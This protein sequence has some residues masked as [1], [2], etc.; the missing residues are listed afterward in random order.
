MTLIAEH[1]KDAATEQE[2]TEHGF[3]R[4]AAG[5]FARARGTDGEDIFIPATLR[6]LAFVSAHAMSAHRPLDVT[7]QVLTGLFWPEMKTYVEARIKSCLSC[8]A[9]LPPVVQRAYGCTLYGD[10]VGATLYMDVCQVTKDSRGREYYLLIRDDLSKYTSVHVLEACDSQHV[11][12]AFMDFLQAHSVIPD[13]I[14]TDAGSHFAALFESC[15]KTLGIAHVVNHPGNHKATGAAERTIRTVNDSL[16]SVLAANGCFPAQWTTYLPLVVL[17]LNNTRYQQL[18][19][20]APIE[21]WSGRPPLTIADLLTRSARITPTQPLTEEQ[22]TAI[23]RATRE[24]LAR[25]ETD[26]LNR[27]AEQRAKEHSRRAHGH[28]VDNTPLRVGDYVL[29]SE[30]AFPGERG[31]REYKLSPK[32]LGPFVIVCAVNANKWTVRRLGSEDNYDVL[33]E[34]LRV[35]HPLDDTDATLERLVRQADRSVLDRYVVER[36]LGIR[37]AP[38]GRG[39][40]VH[41]SWVGYDDSWDSW[42]PFERLAADI[43]T[44]L[45]AFVEGPECPLDAKTKQRL[46]NTIYQILK[47]RRVRQQAERFTHIRRRVFYEAEAPA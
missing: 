19:N 5:H 35:Y 2:A 20:H 4:A 18:A 40:L 7:L 32:W 6:D 10:R 37:P 11:Q 43:P 17:A 13:C 9:R 44:A 38:K 29:V 27:V 14:V 26:A 23:V 16:V 34:H 15:L 12:L 45:R 24:R 33:A 1:S 25:M 28:A 36:F 8:K 46:T 42:E 21:L 22:L 47:E 41:V 31:K 30:R 39:Y 3:V